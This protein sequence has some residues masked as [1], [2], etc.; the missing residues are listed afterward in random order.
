[1]LPYTSV[2]LMIL[3]SWRLET[4]MALKLKEENNQNQLQEEQPSTSKINFRR[5][6]LP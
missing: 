2:V 4:E 6:N 5:S 1:L 3:M